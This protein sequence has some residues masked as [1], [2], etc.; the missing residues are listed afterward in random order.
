[1]AEGARCDLA[2]LSVGAWTRHPAWRSHTSRPAVHG[3]VLGFVSSD[4][5]YLRTEA[6]LVALLS[7]RTER[8]IREL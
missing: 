2:W 3:Y 6:V 1:M 8:T 5:R 7:E 4:A